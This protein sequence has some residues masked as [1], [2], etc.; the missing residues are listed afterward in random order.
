MAPTLRLAYFNLGPRAEGARRFFLWLFFSSFLTL[1]F[2]F[3]FLE[4]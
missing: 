1:K 2:H 4:L 3:Y